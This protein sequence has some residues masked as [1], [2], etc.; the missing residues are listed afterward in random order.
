MSFKAVTERF[1]SEFNV[2]WDQYVASHK[3]LDKFRGIEITQK[4]L[5]SINKI[6]GRIQDQ[7]VLLLPA[8]LFIGKWHTNAALAIT[9]HQKFMDDIKAS[10]ATE[11]GH[12]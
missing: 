8:L 2:L 12:A 9:E 5:E 7:F 3:E 10:G 1:E 11:E 4:N 6:V